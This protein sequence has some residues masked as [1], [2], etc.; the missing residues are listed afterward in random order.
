M[1]HAQ[2][3]TC[4][5][6]C[7]PGSAWSLSFCTVPSFGAGCCVSS[8]PC[9]PNREAGGSDRIG[10]WASNVLI[11]E[12]APDGSGAGGVTIAGAD[13]PTHFLGVTKSDGENKRVPLTFIGEQMRFEGVAGGSVPFETPPADRLLRVPP[14]PPVQIC[15]GW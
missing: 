8:D 13:V 5:D 11:I 9:L 7:V 4:S 2:R 1:G 6:L 10:F 12:K 14:V 3:S 15:P